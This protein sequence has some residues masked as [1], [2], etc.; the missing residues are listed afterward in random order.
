MLIYSIELGFVF[1]STKA[2]SAYSEYVHVAIVQLSSLHRLGEILERG[3]LEIT[4]Y[5]C[6]NDS[7]HSP[8]S[9]RGEG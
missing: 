6:Y 2:Y 7:V 8:L 5:S 1:P 4:K 9:K 3:T